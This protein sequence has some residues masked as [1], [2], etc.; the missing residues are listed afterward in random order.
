MIL[1]PGSKGV[2]V[3]ELQEDLVKLGYDPGT[4]DGDYGPKTKAAV[5]EFQLAYTDLDDDGIAGPL[6]LAKLMTVVDN[7]PQPEPANPKCDDRTWHAFEGLVDLVTQHP[8]KYGPGRGLWSNNRFV[9]THGPGALGSKLWK[10]ALGKSYPS[11]H[12]TSWTN[13][14]L[15][16]L[17]RRNELYTHAGNIPDLWDHGNGLLETDGKTAHLIPGGGTF[18]GYGEDCAPITPNGS[19]AK[20]SGV[21]GVVDVTELLDRRDELP[22]FIV[23]GQSTRQGTGWKWWHH[24]VLFANRDNRLYRIA[25]D[26]FR[27]EANGYSAWPMKFVEITYTNAKHYSGLIYKPYGVLANRDGA[28]GD[29]SKPIASVEIE[30]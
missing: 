4:I 7:I 1:R 10:N 14:F 9:I 29:Q 16:W 3:K 30:A 17:L 26:G 13:F 21:S 24:T 22:S 11:F 2:E 19:G 15:G 18:R 27:N 8:I 12:C 6:T 28:F 5:L 23:C 20:R 25:A